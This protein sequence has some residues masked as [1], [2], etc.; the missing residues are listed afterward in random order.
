M[1]I[2]F[3]LCGSYCTN[4]WS[5]NYSIFKCHTSIRPAVSIYNILSL[6]VFRL[7]KQWSWHTHS[8]GTV[9]STTGC[10][11]CN[12][13]RSHVGLIFKGR[14]SSSSSCIWPLKIKATTQSQTLGNEHLVPK[15]RAKIYFDL[16]LV[17]WHN[18]PAAMHRV[19]LKFV[20]QVFWHNIFFEIKGQ[21]HRE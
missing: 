20:L 11:F 7:L 1:D 10:S 6:L 9:R 17:K 12:V 5:Y 14:T 3:I 21:K 4:E 19:A 2:H 15:S 16:D 13:L 18:N 8:S